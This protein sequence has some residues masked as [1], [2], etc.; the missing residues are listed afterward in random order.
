MGFSFSFE[1][2]VKLAR[3]VGYVS[4]GDC[5]IPLQP[6]WQLLLSGT[7][8]SATGGAPLYRDGG[9]C[10]PPCRAAPGESPCS[11]LRGLHR[12]VWNEGCPPNWLSQPVL[13]EKCLLSKSRVMLLSLH[14][15]A[16]DVWVGFPDMEQF[17]SIT[18]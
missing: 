15:M 11:R 14:W 6:G 10:Q 2:A 18:F 12:E 4:A 1:C 3:M 5:G 17:W 7:E 8:P 9:R 16:W 13:R